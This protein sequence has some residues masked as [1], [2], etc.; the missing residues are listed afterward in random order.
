V[1][2]WCLLPSRLRRAS[3]WREDVAD[4]R[5]RRRTRAEAERTE[6]GAAA[7][8]RERDEVTCDLRVTPRLDAKD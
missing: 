5:R 6:A 3:T 7:I 8:L 2:R 4:P 1:D